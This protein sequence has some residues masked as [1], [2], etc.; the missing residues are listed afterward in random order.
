MDEK[1]TSATQ[2]P[3]LSLIGQLLLPVFTSCPS[4]LFH[5]WALL[6]WRTAHRHS[7]IKFCPSFSF[8]TAI[9]APRCE[10]TTAAA[11]DIYF[12]HKSAGKL[13]CTVTLNKLSDSFGC[14]LYLKASLLLHLQHTH[15]EFVQLSLAFPLLEKATSRSVWAVSL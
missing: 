12:H 2:G 10:K 6:L 3:N 8:E 1:T 11:T 14:C 7:S 4:R 15:S 9:C 13:F 5:S